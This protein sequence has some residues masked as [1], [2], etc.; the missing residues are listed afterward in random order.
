M[1]MPDDE[2]ALDQ[3]IAESREQYPF[4]MSIVYDG[5]IEKG[6][7]RE[8][9]LR[10]FNHWMRCSMQDRSANGDREPEIIGAGWFNATPEMLA[11]ALG[12]P[13]G[14]RVTRMERRIDCDDFQIRVEGPGLPATMEGC[15]AGRITPLYR[16]T[17]VR[18][19]EVAPVDVRQVDLVSW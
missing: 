16:Q 7:S 3:A 17:F 13:V 11:G 1:P 18:E 10:F 5:K 6:L 4:E 15:P 9:A 19:G 12:F 2:S 14:V 8:H